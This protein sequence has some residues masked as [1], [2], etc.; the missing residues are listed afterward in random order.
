MTRFLEFL[1]AA[2]GQANWPRQKTNYLTSKGTVVFIIPMDRIW[3]A[4]VRPLFGYLKIHVVK[5]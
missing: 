2:T 4:A 1:G 5:S 3:R